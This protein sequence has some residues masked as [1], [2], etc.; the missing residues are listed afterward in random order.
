[1]S[2]L[3]RAQLENHPQVRARLPLAGLRSRA[4]HGFSARTV[5]ALKGQDLK[6]VDES[7]FS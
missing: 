7:R 5:H 4:R 6:S 1:M 2:A 3:G